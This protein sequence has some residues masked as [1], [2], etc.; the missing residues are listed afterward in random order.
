MS[1]SRR[2]CHPLQQLSHPTIQWGDQTTML[3]CPQHHWG[4]MQHLYNHRMQTSA[5]AGHIV[6]TRSQQPSPCFPPS[7]MHTCMY[8]RILE[9]NASCITLIHWNTQHFPR[10]KHITL[11]S[12]HFPDHLALGNICIEKANAA[13]NQS[14]TFTTPWTQFIHECSHQFMMYWFILPSH[15]SFSPLQ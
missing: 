14:D 11:N 10:T 12:H 1:A 3:D 4:W 15:W 5:S 9:N 13:V 8:S 2:L 6:W 7:R